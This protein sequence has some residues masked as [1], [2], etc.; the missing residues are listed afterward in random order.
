[1]K[2]ESIE[3]KLIKELDDKRICKLTNLSED[4]YYLHRKE[5][6]RHLL[7]VFNISDKQQLSELK[8]QRD[9]MLQMLERTLKI[10]GKGY[11][12]KENVEDTIGSILYKEIEQLIKKVKNE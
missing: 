6:A 3:D 2:K 10:Y 9:E 4:I 12:P 11:A 5:I 1:M 7:E 8:E